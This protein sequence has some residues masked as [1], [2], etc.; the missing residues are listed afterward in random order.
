MAE[1]ARENKMVA[2]YEA[3]FGDVLPGDILSFWKHCDTPMTEFWFPRAAESAGQDDFKP[4]LPCASSA[5]IY[6]KTRVSAEAF[7]TTRL[8]WIED[9]KRL[10]AC[11]NHAFSR[12]VTHLVFHTYTHNP[13]VGWKL[14]GTSFGTSIGTPFIRGQVWWKYMP[15]F[16]TWAT[17]CG[18]MLEYG[19]PASDILWFLG[20]EIDHKPNERSPF[21]HGYKYDYINRDALLNRI[22]VKNGQ[23]VAPDGASWKV[24]WVPPSYVSGVVKGR[25]HEFVQAGAKVVFGRNFKIEEDILKVVEGITPDVMCGPDIL[26]RTITD[27]RK[28]EQ[29]IDWIHR[30]GKDMDCYFVAANGMDAYKGDV[31]FR[32]DG[33][34]S[35]W[36]P[37]TGE[38]TRPEVVSAGN[39]LTTLRLDLAPA[40][41]IFVVFSRNSLDVKPVISTVLPTEKSFRDLRCL[42]DWSLSFPSGWGAPDSIQLKKLVSWTDLPI[43]K[44]GRHF[45]GTATYNTKFQGVKGENVILDLGDVEFVAEVF[46]NGN[47]VCALWSPPYRCEIGKFVENGENDLRVDVT[48]TWFNRLAFDAGLPKNEQKTW[49]ISAPRKG[50]S[51]RPAG[52]LGPVTLRR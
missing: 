3:A 18:V 43:S 40:E 48:S 32:K 33:D 21:P 7:T 11:A 23:F 36:N 44:E 35:I 10:K 31:T 13:Q 24:L 49:T 8:S 2:Q 51:P 39:G 25:L 37:V 9:F 29:P 42:Q 28:Y 20:E 1:I 52:L 27:W 50:T 22:S 12:G 4:I 45:S 26:G 5:H 6:G 47:K 38:I 14:P 19:K 16:T 41:N 46:V 17:R 30:H 15:E 34:V